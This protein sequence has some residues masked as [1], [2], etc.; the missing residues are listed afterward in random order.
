M[1]SEKLV[2][3]SI[4]KIKEKMSVVDPNSEI[5]VLLFSNLQQLPA[6]NSYSYLG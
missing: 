3:L 1:I 4:V 5:L 6:V 2:L